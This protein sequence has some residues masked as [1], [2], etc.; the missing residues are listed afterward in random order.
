MTTFALDDD[1][2]VVVIGSGAS[3]G[4]VANELAQRGVDVVCLEAGPRLAMRDF[5]NDEAE[6]FGKMTW[7]D[8][9]VSTGDSI[10][11]FPMWTCKAVGGTT[12][13]W[14]ASCPR[15][16]PHEMKARSTYGEIENTSLV[17]WPIDYSELAPYYDLAEN[18]LGVT[19]TNGIERL[20]GHNNYKVIEAGAKNLG[21]QQITTNN[22]AINSAPRDGRPGCLQLGFCTSGCAVGAKWS[23][24][25]GEIPAAEKTGH[26]ELRPESMVVRLDQH[27]TRVNAVEYFDAAGKLRRQ[28]AAAVC[29]AAN[30]ADTTRILLL[31]GGGDAPQGLANSS[32]LLG[33]NWMHHQIDTV[34]AIMPGSVNHHRGAHQAGIVKDE[35][36][37]DASR[38]FAGGFNLISVTFTPETYARML[39][40][41]L[42]GKRLAHMLDHYTDLS[43]L[44]IMGEDPPSPSNR[45]TLHPTRKDQY[46]IPVPVMHYKVHPNTK[47]MVRY[48]VERAHELFGSLGATQFYDILNQM[49]ATHNMGTA[50]MGHDPDQS[51]CNPWGQTHDVSNLFVSDGSVFPTAGCANP[52]IT[53]VALAL[54]QAEYLAAQAAQGKV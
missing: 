22:L 30:V 35:A 52:T 32:G 49:P 29:L 50:R 21:Y 45:I 39:A 9:R 27:K 53:I 25:Y 40:P 20:P 44:M 16:Q 6:M 47:R 17:D 38:G 18:R 12:L 36:H 3:G 10:P 48:A 5:V 37:H 43:M 1:S 14:T 24:L 19:G 7:L 23:P 46:G 33:R 13:H 42:W 8:E 4:T 2:V 54:R 51:V 28:R 31:S 26:F 34:A 41:Q 11:N 15:L